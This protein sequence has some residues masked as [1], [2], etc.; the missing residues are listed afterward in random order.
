MGRDG[1]TGETLVK[2]V[3]AP[4]FKSRHLKVQSWIGFNILGDRDGLNLSRSAQKAS[5]IATKSG[6]LKSLLG[7]QPHALVGID[8]VPSLHE[9]KTAW[10]F[11][12]FQG[13]LGTPMVMQFIWQ[14]CDAILAA[15]LILD[16]VRLTV[17]AA[18]RGEKGLMP[19]LGCF[20]KAPE[21]VTDHDFH[22]QVE[23]LRN[24]VS[25]WFPR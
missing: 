6:V 17:A 3:L 20:F 22:K 5:K 2:T 4:M 10:D 24:H 16:M 21:A 15:P 12:H 8:Y 13:F 1:K 11:I 23:I 19:W 25:S 7:Y 14:G 9:W 18:Q